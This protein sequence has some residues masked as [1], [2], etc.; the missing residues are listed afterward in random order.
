MLSQAHQRPSAHVKGGTRESECLTTRTGIEGQ[1][2]ENFWHVVA[3]TF[4]SFQLPHLRSFLF[5]IRSSCRLSSSN[6][7]ESLFGPKCG[8]DGMNRKH[9]FIP[10]RLWIS[11]SASISSRVYLSLST[12][13]RQEPC[14]FRLVG[15][16]SKSP[17]PIVELLPPISKPAIFRHNH[18]LSYHLVYNTA[19]TLAVAQINAFIHKPARS[20][21]SMTKNIS[22]VFSNVLTGSIST[23]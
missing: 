14:S 9:P 6:Q 23:T 7:P 12:N 16:T 3:V 19:K 5:R 18:L 13:S 4:P 1:P 22:A 21:H 10:L 11:I 2:F 15:C 8:T 20:L 17:V